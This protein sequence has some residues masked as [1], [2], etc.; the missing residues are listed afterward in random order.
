M[1]L[2]NP[3]PVDIPGEGR[4]LAKFHTSKGV[5]VAE[6]FEEKAPLTVANFVHLA[7][8]GHKGTPFYDGIIFHRVIPDFMIQ[9]GC[10]DGRGTGGPGYSIPC[11]FGPGLKHDR[12]GVLSMA[13]RG[14]NTGGSQIFITEVATPWL[15]GNHAIFGALIEGLDVQKAIANS[16]RGMGDRPNNDIVI[17]RLEITRG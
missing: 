12:P 6:L 9:V 16:P 13:N 15:D 5:M 11:E 8:G 17:E 1:A 3:P 4:L 2:F 10:P 7:T 14:P